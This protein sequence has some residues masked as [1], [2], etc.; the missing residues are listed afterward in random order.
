MP[1]AP[2][3]GGAG[4]APAPPSRAARSCPPSDGHLRDAQGR[5]A[6]RDRHVLAVL[7]AGPGLEAEG[8]IAADAVDLPQDVDVRA[9]E[10]RLLDR[11]GEVAAFDEI[12]EDDGERELARVLDL[13][14]GEAGDV[15]A[16][17]DRAEDVVGVVETRADIGVGH[18]GD[19]PMAVILAAAVPGQRGFAH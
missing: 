4:R 17:L 8:E 5:A 7:A 3:P 13:V 19:G 15:E 1:R 6:V 11:S 2:R 12:P 18:A 9:D 14:A 10:R 16:F